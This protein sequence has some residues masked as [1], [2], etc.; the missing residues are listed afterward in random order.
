MKGK[1][2]WMIGRMNWMKERQRGG[3]PRRTVTG[4]CRGSWP[5]G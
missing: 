2:R 5:G 3:S 4:Y 1:V